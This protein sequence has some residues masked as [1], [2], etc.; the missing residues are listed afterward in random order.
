MIRYYLAPIVQTTLPNGRTPNVVK[1]F[2]YIDMSQG[3]RYAAMMPNPWKMWG[4]CKIT[5]ELQSTLDDIAGDADI[6]L[7]PFFSN[8]GV[9]L[10]LSATVADVN[11]TDRQKIANFLEERRIPTD[12]IEGG[13]TLREVMRF[14]V[15]LL[16]LVQKL[17]ANFPELDIDDTWS[18]IPA[19]KRTKIRA[20]ADNHNIDYSDVTA[21][22]PIRQILKWFIIRYGW[23]ALPVL[24]GET[25]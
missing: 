11:P 16:M 15:R 25:L 13:T 5:T 10:D 9:Y 23:K 14:V 12:W 24:G 3:D 1:P 8:T 22:T 19:A 6:K 7:I 2:I 4:L 17:K 18:D 21:D 20:W